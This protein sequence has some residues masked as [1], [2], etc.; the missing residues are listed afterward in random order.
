MKFKK[1]LNWSEAVKEEWDWD[2]RNTL[3]TKHESTTLPSKSP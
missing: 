2:C 1:I 3:T